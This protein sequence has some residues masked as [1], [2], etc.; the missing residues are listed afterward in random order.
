MPVEEFRAEW[1]NICAETM[2]RFVEL[3]SGPNVELKTMHTWLKKF[4]ERTF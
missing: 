1:E 2:K 3:F 4:K